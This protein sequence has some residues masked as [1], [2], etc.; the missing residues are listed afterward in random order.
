MELVYNHADYRLMSRRALEALGEYQETSLFLRGIVPMIGY[1]TDCVYYSRG[2]RLAGESKYPLKK[3][4]SF[5][6]DGVTS[7]SVKPLRLLFSFGVILLILAV[8][9]AITALALGQ[10]VGFWGI[11]CLIAAASGVHLIAAGVL[12]EYIGKI[13]LEAKKRP[14]YRIET[15]AGDVAKNPNE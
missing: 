11:F 4:L 12:G 14:R 10:F 9:G 6:M 5:A 1:K 13:Y 7:F 15:T 8:I 3:M 2:E